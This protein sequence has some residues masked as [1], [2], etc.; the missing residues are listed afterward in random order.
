MPMDQKQSTQTISAPHVPDELKKMMA[1]QG[2]HFVGKHSAVKT[3]TYTASSMQLEGA[4]CYKHKFYGIRSWR[5]MQ[6][7]PAI[8][9]NLSCSF[10]WRIIPEEVGINWNELNA[11]G[12]WDDP[13]SIVDGLVVE[14]RKLVSGYKENPKTDLQRWREANDPAHVALSLTGEPFF[15][16][17]MNM[18]IAAFHKRKISTFIVTNGTMV[19]ALRKLT[20]MPTQLYVSVQAPNEEVYNITARAKTLNAWKMFQ[21]FLEVFANI[22]TRRVFR[23][24]LVKGVNM[25]DAK[26]YADLVKK[27]KPDYVEV[28]GFSYVGGARS[29]ERHLAYQQMPRNE[30]V[31]EFAKEIAKESGYLFTDCHEHSRTVLLSVNQETADKR[32]INFEK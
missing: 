22:K 13:D 23:L 3:C 15:Y 4:T 30:E 11:L 26:G 14:Q 18:L 16:P 5:C 6:S 19:N 32:I 2:Y 12:S 27:G 21:E 9:C 10:C 1:R 8:G 31:V 28:K 17:H 24:T 25:I 7:T 29:E 20:V